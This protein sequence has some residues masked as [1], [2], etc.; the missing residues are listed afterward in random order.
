MK[1]FALLGVLACPG[2]ALAGA[3]SAG[4]YGE[5]GDIPGCL[6]GESFDSQPMYGPLPVDPEEYEDY[7]YFADYGGCRAWVDGYGVVDNAAAIMSAAYNGPLGGP[8]P[9]GERGGMLH[10]QRASVGTSDGSY[11]R[12]YTLYTG[13]DYTATPERPVFISLDFYKN[14][15]DDFQGIRQ[16]SDLQDANVSIGGFHP[17]WPLKPLADHRGVPSVLEGIVVASLSSE[18]NN[19]YLGGKDI[20]EHTWFTLG[21]LKSIGEEG[22]ARHTFW[23]RDVDTTGDSGGPISRTPMRTSGPYA[24]TRMFSEFGLGLEEGWTQIYPGTEDDP[25]TPDVIEGYG[26][27]IGFDGDVMVEAPHEEDQNGNRVEVQQRR[28]RYSYTSVYGGNDPTEEQLPGYTMGDWWVDNYCVRG[29]RRLP[30]HN[31]TADINVDG[32]VDAPDLAELLAFWGPSP[33]PPEYN[34][35]YSLSFD[36]FPDVGAPD[37]AVFLASWGACP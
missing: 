12:F 26:L 29:G 33:F 30:R 32:Q 5:T 3:P 27:A 34:N 24:G 9:S 31:C 19:F 8:D 25:A 7:F 18:N 14:T 10:V 22:N 13:S 1:R 15:H 36:N 20:P 4:P 35:Y 11:E 16:Y 23:I 28:E 6:L 2:L 21:M 17:Q 37:L